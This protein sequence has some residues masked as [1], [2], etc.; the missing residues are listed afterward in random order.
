MHCQSAPNL[1]WSQSYLWLYPGAEHH[2]A[3]LNLC[4]FNLKFWGARTPRKASATTTTTTTTS[5]TT[6][7]TTREYA[8]EY[9]QEYAHTLYI[10]IH[11]HIY[12]Q[13]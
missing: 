7:T 12:L 5:T 11:T 10:C 9:A 6:T 3:D 4:W 1:T 8:Q 2:L 13:E